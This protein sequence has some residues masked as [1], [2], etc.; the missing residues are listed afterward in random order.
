[1][2]D[3]KDDKTPPKKTM[4]ELLAA[5]AKRK[6]HYLSLKDNTNAIKG[7]NRKDNPWDDNNKS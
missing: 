5:K 6:P 4:Q 7:A 3:Q 1:M 2:T